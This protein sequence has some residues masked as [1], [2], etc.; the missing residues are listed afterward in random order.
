MGKSEEEE[1]LEKPQLTLILVRLYFTRA[2][3]IGWLVWST[4][5]ACLLTELKNIVKRESNA[6]CP[7]KLS[8]RE[9]REHAIHALT[10]FTYI[11]FP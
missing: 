5:L 8:V 1:C 3:L 6:F 2:I 4:S 7:Y 9:A 11:T 10:V